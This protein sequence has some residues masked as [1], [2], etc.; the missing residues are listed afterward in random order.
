MLALSALTDDARESRISRWKANK[1]L[2]NRG[3]GEIREGI[4][5]FVYLRPQKPP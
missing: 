3:R 1:S 5:W 2:A 4:F